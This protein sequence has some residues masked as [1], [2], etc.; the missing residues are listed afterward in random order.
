MQDT[1]LTVLVPPPVADV[2][3]LGLD[4]ATVAGLTPAAVR[5][6]IRI[7]V[8]QPED[9]G[10]PLPEDDE[11]M[12]DG[13]PDPESPDSGGESHWKKHVWTADEDAK[14]LALVKEGQGKVRWSVVGANMEG[15]SGKRAHLLKCY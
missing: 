15:R 10:A 7:V 11:S 6:N 9:L 2:H 8:Q 14:L 13:S 3:P 1:S 12:E 4:N 5:S